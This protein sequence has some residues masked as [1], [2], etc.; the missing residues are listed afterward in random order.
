[1][2]DPYWKIMQNYFL[3]PLSKVCQTMFQG[4]ESRGERGARKTIWFHAWCRPQRRRWEEVLQHCQQQ[5]N[6]YKQHWTLSTTNKQI[7]NNTKDIFRELLQSMDPKHLHW[8]REEAASLVKSM[9]II[10][11]IIIMRMLRMKMVRRALK[12]TNGRNLQ[13]FVHWILM[14]KHGETNL[15]VFQPSRVM[16]RMR[17]LS[18]LLRLCWGWWGEREWWGYDEEKNKDDNEGDEKKLRI[19]TKTFLSSSWQTQTRMAVLTLKRWNRC[20]F[21]LFLFLL[22]R[23]ILW[24]ILHQNH[25]HPIMHDNHE[26]HSHQWK[27]HFFQMVA[28]SEAFLTSKLVSPQRSFHGEL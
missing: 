19:L 16:V 4:F 21:N 23:P 27:V 5:T 17:M 13:I 6:K 24:D 12:K 10:I 20:F 14:L 11:I 28:Q 8:A 25:N 26:N 3:V 2:F 9:I 15:G 1:M 18:M 7:Q 22:F